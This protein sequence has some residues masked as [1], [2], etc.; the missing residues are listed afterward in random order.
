MT[1]TLA[2]YETEVLKC[3]LCQNA[4]F[5]R[6][7][8]HL[9]NVHHLC[10]AERRY[11]LSLA[12]QNKLNVNGRNNVLPQR[13]EQWV[14]QTKPSTI[15]ETD[16]TTFNNFVQ[17]I[18][19]LPMG[20]KT[21]KQLQKYKSQMNKIWKMGTIGRPPKEVYNALLEAYY[22]YLQNKTWRLL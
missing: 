9:Q 13:V 4:N 16:N 3:P 20:F 11:Y 22:A 6:L 14:E 5:K 1:K 10:Q 21:L 19:Y 12:R 17:A 2:D 15:N 18:R 7:R 8:C